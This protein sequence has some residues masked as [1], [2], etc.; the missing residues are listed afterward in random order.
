MGREREQRVRERG[1]DGEIIHLEGT[2]K[3]KQTTK[4]R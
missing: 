3:H 4:I 1:Q 2:Q